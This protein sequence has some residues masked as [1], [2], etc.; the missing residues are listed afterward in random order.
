[1][2]IACAVLAKAYA[3]INPIPGT[4]AQFSGVLRFNSPGVVRSPCALNASICK[5]KCKPRRVFEKVRG[6]RL[7]MT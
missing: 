2:V 7:G 6:H 1:M 4:D 5:S 3:K